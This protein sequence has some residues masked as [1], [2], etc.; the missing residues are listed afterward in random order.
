MQKNSCILGIDYG[1]KRIGLALSDSLKIIATPIGFLPAER[2]LPLTLEKLKAKID[3][4]CRER[5]A[6][7]EEI[8]VGM[9]YKMNKEDSKMTLEV[10]AFVTAL[11]NAIDI[12]VVIWDERFT[13]KIAEQSLRE[14]G[15]SRKQR[16]E[17]VDKVA[18][19]L[20]LQ[21]YLDSK[22]VER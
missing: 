16:V 21:N 5:G 22:S 7:I 14:G 10:K 2:K 9:P 12:P 6:T 18:A 13:S 8:V 19:A 3:E 1:Q 15:R 11:S 4:L 20:V 17:E